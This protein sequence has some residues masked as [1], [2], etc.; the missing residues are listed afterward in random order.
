[1]KKAIVIVLLLILLIG[2]GV[3]G[4]AVMGISPFDKLLGQKQDGAKPEEPPPA[5][6]G[7]PQPEVAYYEAGSYI[8]PVV[9]NHAIVRQVGIDLAIAVDPAQ[10]TRVGSA[11]PKLQD[12][13]TRE[14][15]DT[16]PRYHD[17]KLEAN[18]RAIH[19]RLLRVAN[20]MFGEGAIRDVTI[21]SIYDR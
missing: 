2:G 20:K 8:I 15:F 21:K 19:D 11:L 14:L 17:T 16:I 9:Q 13:F 5:P 3:G 7:P 12:A 6:K 18:R 4:A 10:I 1:M